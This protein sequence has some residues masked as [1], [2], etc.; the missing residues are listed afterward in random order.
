MSVSP[1]AVP[2]CSSL[3]LSIWHG[4]SFLI[5]VFSVLALHMLRQVRISLSSSIEEKHTRIFTRSCSSVGTAGKPPLQ[6]GKLPS[7]PSCTPRTQGGQPLS[8]VPWGFQFSL[9]IALLLFVVAA[10]S[11][12]RVRLFATPWTAAPQASLSFTVSRSLLKLMSFEP[13]MPL[14]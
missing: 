6:F 12:S 8:T 9:W 4:I 3:C 5:Y 10:Q 1:S 2:L 13:M 14:V 7:P 11:L